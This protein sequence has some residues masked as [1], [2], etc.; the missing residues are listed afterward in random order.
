M[1]AHFDGVKS[2]ICGLRN[3]ESRLAAQN[4]TPN[5]TVSL[6]AGSDMCKHHAPASVC[7]AEICLLS[8]LTQP[9]LEETVPADLTGGSL[10]H[11]PEPRG[12]RTSGEDRHALAQLRKH[13]AHDSI[14]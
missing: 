11:L 7:C 9:F 5:A 4:I 8:S 3:S 14:D 12:P 1:I 6:Q 10:P 13:H 2:I